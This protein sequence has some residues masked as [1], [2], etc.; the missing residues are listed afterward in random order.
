MHSHDP[1][2]SDAEFQAEFE[3][4]LREAG[5]GLAD[6][7]GFIFPTSRYFGRKFLATCYFGFAKFTQ[8]AD[9]RF[10]TFT[11]NAHF[12]NVVFVQDVD[13]TCA[14]F[15]EYANFSGTTFKQNADFSGA[16]VRRDTNFYETTF[17]QNATFNHATFTQNVEF[18]KATFTQDVDFGGSTFGGMVDLHRARFVGMPSFERTNFMEHPQGK[19]HEPGPVFAGATFEQPEKVVF[20]GTYLGHVLFHDCDVSRMNFSD[21]VWRKRANGKWMVFDEVIDPQHGAAW[22]LRPPEGN[23]NPRNYRL[24]AE[25][26]QQ[27][28][29]NYDDQRDYWTAGDFHYGEMEMKRLASDYHNKILRWLHSNLGLVACYKYA[30]EYGESYVRPGLLLLLTL[31]VFTLLYPLAGLRHDTARDRATVTERNST[32]RASV[33]RLTYWSPQR[34]SDDTRP[35]W[36]TR[37]ALV[38]YSAITTVGVSLFLKDLPYEPL[39]PWGASLKVTEM[40]LTSILGALFLLAVRRQF[41]R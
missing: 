32:A 13:F 3:C 33:L 15:T 22:A 38:G 25:L 39:D 21:V 40:I 31:F 37:L 24:I 6:F 35:L 4:V 26:Y 16:K 17:A 7:S 34:G 20:N 41:K 28:K 27:L 19:D 29:K 12:I 10:A 1:E 5:D 2:K 11:Q 23:P 9:F 14:E 8:E 30:S 36:Q 18:L